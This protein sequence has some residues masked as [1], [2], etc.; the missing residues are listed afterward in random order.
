M[1]ISRNLYFSDGWKYRL[2]QDFYYKIHFDLEPRK[3]FFH[4][5]GYYGLLQDKDG[6]WWI[7]ARIGCCWDGPSGPMPDHDFM[8]APS[9]VHD[10]LHWLIRR[11]IIPEKHNNLIDAELERAIN[12]YDVSPPLW[13]G[14]DLFGKLKAIR[15][16]IIRR[17]TNTCDEVAG[18]RPPI[19]KIVLLA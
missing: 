11:E 10:I 18:S 12:F 19:K 8:M 4:E 7:H 16:R 1:E 5:D 15:A 6:D 3:Q 17:A 9:L 13:Q 14:G 2:E